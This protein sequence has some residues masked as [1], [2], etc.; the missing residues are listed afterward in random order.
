M[1]YIF[2]HYFLNHYI[3]QVNSMALLKFNFYFFHCHFI[4]NLHFILM[5]VIFINYH[6]KY[7]FLN[8]YMNQVNLMVL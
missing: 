7:Y 5:K 8:F 3:N 1:N 4:F 2:K 6:F